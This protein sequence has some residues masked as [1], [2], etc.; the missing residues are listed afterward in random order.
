[1]LR[2]FS[3]D[4]PRGPVPALGVGPSDGPLPPA[5]LLLHGLGAWKDVHLPELNALAADGWLAIAPDLP[6]H[7]DR[8]D[9]FLRALEQADAVERHARFLA[10]V[11]ETAEEVSWLLD[12]CLA[13]GCPSVSLVGISYGAFTA[14]SVAA[15]DRRPR[16]VVSLLGSPDWS[17]PAGGT[18]DGRARQARA[19]RA[20]DLAATALLLIQAG[21]DEIVLADGAR[22]LHA[23][24]TARAGSRVALREYPSSGH[25]MAPADWDDAWASTRA[26]LTT[27]GRG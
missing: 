18:A 4:T 9:G 7:G 24:L 23:T 5:V 10:L 15:R 1:M 12:R 8:D 21:R 17:G 11:E 3:F 16:A 6:H 14:L 2:R 27:W 13:W 20:D 22:A 25:E 26:W 19:P